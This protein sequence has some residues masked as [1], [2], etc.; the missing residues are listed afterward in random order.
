VGA[1][2]GDNLYVAIPL[3]LGL[4]VVVVGVVVVVVVIGAYTLFAY[5]LAFPGRMLLPYF[6]SLHCGHV[7]LH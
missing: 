6:A 7:Y 2:R 4:V 1:T 5:T 3:L